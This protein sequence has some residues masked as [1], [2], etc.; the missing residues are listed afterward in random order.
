M[1]DNKML[2]FIWRDNEVSLNVDINESNLL[3]IMIDYAHVTKKFGYKLD[4]THPT[5]NYMYNMDQKNSY[6]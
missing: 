1:C 5:F 6:D 2:K 4:Y 3:D